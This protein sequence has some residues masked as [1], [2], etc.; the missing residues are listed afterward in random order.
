MPLLDPGR[1]LGRGI[2]FPPKV[3]ADGRVRWSE[4]ADNV[5]DCIQVILGTERR[6]RL[7]LPEF[8]GGLARAL[9]EPNDVATRTRI[10]DRIQRALRL[11]EPRIDL[12]SVEVRP[13]PDDPRAA[14]ASIT[15]KLVATQ[16]R[17]RLDLTVALTG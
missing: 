13:D 4:G 7:M 12:E 2:A 17:E 8:G 6:E 1:V 14:I 3:G 9:F 16:S 15:Y 5:R 11:W 10:G